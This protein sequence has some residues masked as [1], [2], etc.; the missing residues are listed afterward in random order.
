MSLGERLKQVRESL[1]Y[2]QKEMAQAIDTNP[3]TWRVYEANK[4][5]PGGNVLEALARMGFN[6]NW[7]LTGVGPMKLN[8]EDMRRLL[9]EE[10]HDKL[11]A[12]IRSIATTP[13]RLYNVETFPFEQIQAYLEDDYWPDYEQILSLC[14][15]AGAAF[16]DKE[17]IDVITSVD[18][19]YVKQVAKLAQEA[20]SK[21][22]IKT[23]DD[24]ILHN[25]LKGISEAFEDACGD[26]NLKTTSYSLEDLTELI[27]FCY[28][29]SINDSDTTNDEYKKTRVKR[30]VALLNKGYQ[31]R[32]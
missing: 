8:K 19:R 17:F 6:V 10:A 2:S 14:K 5:V 26:E 30:L 32:Q 9:C 16:S 11:K 27:A 4:S 28:D 29:A 18:L 25:V 31:S 13:A 1:S 20:N 22:I 7:I 12:K 23:I 3:Q 15:R 24:N 21:E